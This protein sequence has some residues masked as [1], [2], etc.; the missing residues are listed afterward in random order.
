V[1]GANL[2]GATLPSETLVQYSALMVIEKEYDRDTM[3]KFLECEMNNYLLSR[4]R[5]LLKERPLLTMEAN[6][7]YIHSRKG[8]V[9]MYH[10]R[11]LIGEEGV[12]RAARKVLQEYGYAPPPYPT[13]YAL[14]DA[15]RQETPPQSQYL[16]KDLFEDITLL[17]NRALS[18][19]AR[20]RSDGKYDVTIQLEA[21]KFKADDQGNQHEVP[22][23]VWIEIGALAAP[24]KGKKYGKVLHRE[25][26]HMSTGYPSLPCRPTPRLS[27]IQKRG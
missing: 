11:E 7:G 2:E 5:E 14:V 21:R 24:Q 15:L 13:S 17:S 16:I 27:A 25:R 18:A 3:R 26:E 22:V 20:K 4:V 9:V 10:L 1:I 19:K 12:N 8:S 6:Q 23:N